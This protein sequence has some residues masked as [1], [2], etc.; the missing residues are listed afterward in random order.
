MVDLANEQLEKM[1]GRYILVSRP[2]SDELD[3]SVIDNEQAGEI[4]PTENL[5]GGERFIISLALALGLSGLSGKKSRI[6]SLFL[7]EGFGSLDEEALNTALEALGELHRTGRTI[8]IISHVA[9]LRERITAQIEVIHKSD[10]VSIIKGPG[11]CKG[12]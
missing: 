6:E 2:D 7:D 4:R 11:V 3:L 9:A 1:N 10:G 8:G 5:S 12:N